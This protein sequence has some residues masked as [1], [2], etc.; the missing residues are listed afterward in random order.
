LTIP[1]REKIRAMMDVNETEEESFRD[2]W[3]LMKKRGMSSRR[4]VGR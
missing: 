2:I 4:N 1:K 3:A